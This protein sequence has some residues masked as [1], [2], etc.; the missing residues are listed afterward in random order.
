MVEISE[1]RRDSTIEL[2]HQAKRELAERGVPSIEILAELNRF[3]ASWQAGESL[4]ELGPR[5]RFKKVHNGDCGRRGILLYETYVYRGKF[6]AVVAWMELTG[7]GVLGM[8]FQEAG[9]CAK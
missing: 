2:L 7:P 3:E 6:R 4:Q 9:R 1:V 5:Y 8:D